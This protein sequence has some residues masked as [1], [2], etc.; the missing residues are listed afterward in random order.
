MPIVNFENKTGFIVN[1]T[2]PRK[3]K[4][5]DADINELKDGVNEKIVSVKG[6]VETEVDTIYFYEINSDGS[7]GL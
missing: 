3:N 2:I 6:T 5:T 1:S 7:G 4:V